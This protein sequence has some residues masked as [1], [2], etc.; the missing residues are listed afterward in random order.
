MRRGALHLAGHGDFLGNL[1]DEELVS[2]LQDDVLFTIP[3]YDRL[4]IDDQPTRGMR[5]AEPVQQ[6]LTRYEPL[7]PLLAAEGDRGQLR[8]EAVG[9][10]PEVF[11]FPPLEFRAQEYGSLDKGVVRE[12]T[13]PLQQSG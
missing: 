9:Q 8:L 13:G 10:L 2:P 5:V 1:R 11:L 4:Q 3:R 6:R 12:A 7:S